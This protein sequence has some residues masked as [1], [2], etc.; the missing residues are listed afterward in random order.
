MVRLF[1]VNRK[2]RGQRALIDLETALHAYDA[3]LFQVFGHLPQIVAVEGRIPPTDEDQIALHLTIDDTAGRQKA[4]LEHMIRP[5]LIQRIKRG[6]RLDAAGGR[7]AIGGVGR[8]Q[9]DAG[10]DVDHGKGHRAGDPAVGDDLGHIGNGL[11]IQVGI[12]PHGAQR[13]GRRLGPSRGRRQRS[14]SRPKEN[15]ACETS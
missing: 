8:L 12:A 7:D 4:R 1:G 6:D 11:F 5:Q 14:G 2:G 10:V 3:R 13:S 15:A 9:P